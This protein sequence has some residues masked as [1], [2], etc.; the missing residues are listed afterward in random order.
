MNAWSQN[1]VLGWVR[2]ST[3][4]NLITLKAIV[5]SQWNDTRRKYKFKRVL[6]ADSDFKPYPGIIFHLMTEDCLARRHINRNCRNS[7]KRVKS[8]KFNTMPWNFWNLFYI[9]KTNFR[10]EGSKFD[11]KLM[12]KFKTKFRGCAQFQNTTNSKIFHEILKYLLKFKKSSCLIWAKTLADYD[13]IFWK[14]HQI[15]Q[16][17]QIRLTGWKGVFERGGTLLVYNILMPVSNGY[18]TC[19]IGTLGISFVS[20]KSPTTELFVFKVLP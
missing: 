19:P 7:E 10:E 20:C 12:K 16:F 11:C 9:L 5:L 15:G 8:I 14:Y 18:Q 1:A 2:M 6:N 17:M 3:T 4:T 13:W